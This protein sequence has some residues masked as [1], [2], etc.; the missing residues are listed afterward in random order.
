MSD[1]DLQHWLGQRSGGAIEFYKDINEEKLREGYA[2]ANHISID[3]RQL[4]QLK[5]PA[6]DEDKLPAEGKSAPS[7][8]LGHGFCTYDFFDQCSQ[9]M[10]CAQ[11]SFYKPKASLLSQSH[12]VKSQFVRMLHH[13]PL[14]N[15]IRQA[16]EEAIALNEK[17]EAIIRRD[18]ESH[19]G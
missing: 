17:M 3:K 11:C 19:P 13:L 1:S 18:E 8:D 5:K 16:I 7:V 2:A 15:E 9:R 10:P 4:E 14:S 12:E 6:T